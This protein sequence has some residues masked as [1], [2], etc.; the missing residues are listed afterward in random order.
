MKR[1]ILILLMILVFAVTYQVIAADK[2]SFKPPVLITS[3]GQSTDALMAK[4]LMSKNNIEFTYN[5][6]AQPEELTDIK[7]VIVAVGASSKGLGAAGIDFDSEVNRT[8]KLIA[9]MKEKDISVILVHLGGKSRRGPSSDIL[10]D[11]VIPEADY[12]I[13]TRDGN[14]D[15]F[16]DEKA[17]EFGI[18]LKI[19]DAISD[20]GECF[21][22]VFDQ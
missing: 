13:V 9:K 2:L 20:A 5:T 8:K 7:T 15:G 3:L 18:T 22:E 10:L 6:L 12:M 11:M 21:K 19:I 4:V 17:K 14:S 16:F 1:I